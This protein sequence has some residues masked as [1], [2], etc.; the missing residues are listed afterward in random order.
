MS[1]QLLIP[2]PVHFLGK[3]LWGYRNTLLDI[4]DLDLIVKAMRPHFVGFFTTLTCE[5]DFF[6][7]TGLLL[8][9]NIWLGCYPIGGDI[10]S[11]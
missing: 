8:F 4:G 3:I 1:Q 11:F 9:I 5:Q 10:I 6:L 2:L 7:F